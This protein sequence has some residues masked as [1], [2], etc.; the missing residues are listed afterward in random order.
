MQILAR[1][2]SKGGNLTWN[3]VKA[4]IEHLKTI[5]A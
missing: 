1:Q 3:Q 5:E 2:V 4:Q